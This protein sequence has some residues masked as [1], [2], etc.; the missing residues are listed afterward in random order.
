MSSRFFRP[1]L[2]MGALAVAVPAVVAAAMT[3]PAA[4]ASGAANDF[5][6]TNLVSN[7]GDQGAQL[8]DPGLVNPWGLAL[9]P[10]SPLWVADN[11]ADLSTVYRITPGGATAAKV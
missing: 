1:R 4:L 2:A 7:R 11:G 9:S 3:V 8:V 6:Q 5:H 10:T